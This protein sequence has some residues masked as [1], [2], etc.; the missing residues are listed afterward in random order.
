[1]EGEKVLDLTLLDFGRVMYRDLGRF[2]GRRWLSRRM[3]RMIEH[4]QVNQK[5]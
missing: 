2:D 1:V 5:R 4:V 3:M